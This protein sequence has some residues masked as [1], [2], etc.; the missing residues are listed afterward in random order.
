VTGL[1]TVV[2][3]L[4][5]EDGEDADIEKGLDGVAT[6][7][8][9]LVEKSGGT[10]ITVGHILHWK[11]FPS[12]IVKRIGKYWEMKRSLWMKGQL[13]GI[14]YLPIDHKGCNMHK[15]GLH[16]TDPGAK[17]YFGAVIDLST[18][19][20][21][22]SNTGQSTPARSVTPSLTDW[23]MMDATPSRDTEK[24]TKKRGLTP[25]PDLAEAKRS[26]QDIIVDLD[27]R[28]VKISDYAVDRKTDIKSMA[29]IA[30][31]QDTIENKLNLHKIVIQ[32]LKIDGI[33]QLERGE[34]RIGPMK[35]AVKEFMKKLMELVNDMPMKE[36]TTIYLVNERTM[37]NDP[38]KKPML[39]V[40]FGDPSFAVNLRQIYGRMNAAWKREE[41]GVPVPF[42]GVFLNPCLNHRT[43]VRLSVFKA[44]AKA[45]NVHHSKDS[46]SAWMIDHLPRPM[47]KISEKK[48]DG[49]ERAKVLGYVDAV[50]LAQNEGLVGDQDL[51]DAHKLAG[52]GYGRSLENFFVLLK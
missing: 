39:E 8:E 42:R 52:R 29:K 26:K 44:I 3:Q 5:E 15:D 2:G 21:S 1:E 14:Q 51:I 9:N 45:Y 28:Y 50:T 47:L 27:K 40:S 10:L 36:I 32:G 23:N 43:R 46:F 31:D 20:F 24:N 7:M 22:A 18:K 17:A 48:D 19:F 13:K 33:L 34:A 11:Q 4:L 38:K 41:N 12:S 49:S 37:R 35:E 30:E 16:L 6:A 25:P